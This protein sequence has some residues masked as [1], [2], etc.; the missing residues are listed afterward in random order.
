[1]AHFAWTEPHVNLTA[2]EDV[3]AAGKAS[4]AKGTFGHTCEFIE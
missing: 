4:A 2:C 3:F 1:M